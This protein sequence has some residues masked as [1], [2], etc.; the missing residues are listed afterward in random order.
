VPDHQSPNAWN[1]PTKPQRLYPH[2]LSCSFTTRQ[3]ATLE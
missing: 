3:L 1:S 2:C